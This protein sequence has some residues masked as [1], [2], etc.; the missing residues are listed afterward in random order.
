MGTEKVSG[1][2]AAGASN[3]LNYITL[4]AEFEKKNNSSKAAQ[5]LL[6]AAEVARDG[7]LDLKEIAELG[8][9]KEIDREVD[10]SMTLKSGGTANSEITEAEATK[11]FEV[12]RKWAE[13]KYHKLFKTNEAQALK[14]AQDEYFEAQQF[15]AAALDEAIKIAEGNVSL[16]KSAAATSTESIEDFLKNIKKP[17]SQGGGPVFDSNLINNILVHLKEE[18]SKEKTTKVSE[19]GSQKEAILED[20][21]F[22][23]EYLNLPNTTREVRERATQAQQTAGVGRINP[24]DARFIDTSPALTVGQQI[25]TKGNLNKSAYIY[26]NTPDFTTLSP[27]NK[28]NVLKQ[29]IT[30]AIADEEHLLDSIGLNDDDYASYIA[31]GMAN[32][33]ELLP[34]IKA[35]FANV[36]TKAEL[37]KSYKNLGDSSGQEI[38]QENA[39]TEVEYLIT[40]M[41]DPQNTEF[42]K[43]IKLERYLSSP[44]NK[45]SLNTKT[46]EYFNQ[47]GKIKVQDGSLESVISAIKEDLNRTGSIIDPT[48]RPRIASPELNRQ[49]DQLLGTLRDVYKDSAGSVIKKD[50]A[51]QAQKTAGVN[52]ILSSIDGLGLSSIPQSEIDNYYTSHKEG[53]SQEKVTV[54]LRIF[55]GSSGPENLGEPQTFVKGKDSLNQ[56]RYF[57]V[58]KVQGKDIAIEVTDLPPAILEAIFSNL[59]SQDAEQ[60]FMVKN[61]P[62]GVYKRYKF[63]VEKK[64]TVSKLYE[65]VVSLPTYLDCQVVTVNNKKI[66]VAE[67]KKIS[68]VVSERLKAEK[69]AGYW[70]NPSQNLPSG[71][72][73][74]AEIIQ[75]INSAKAAL[76]YDQYQPAKELPPL[77]KENNEQVEKVTS[78]EA[79]QQNQ[80]NTYV[81]QANNNPQ[82]AL[83][84]IF[85]LFIVSGVAEAFK[86][87]CVVEIM[88]IISKDNVTDSM[89]DALRTESAVSFNKAL[90]DLFKKAYGTLKDNPQFKKDKAQN[91]IRKLLDDSSFQ[92]ET[93]APAGP[94]PAASGTAETSNDSTARTVSELQRQLTL[95]FNATNDM[96]RSMTLSIIMQKAKRIVESSP[97]TNIESL[98]TVISSNGNDKVTGLK[99]ALKNF[100]SAQKSTYEPEKSKLDKFFQELF[101]DPDFKLE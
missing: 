3:L 1:V 23:H 80:L 82:D 86:E 75:Q 42:Q 61:T 90:S 10:S 22:Y 85:Q 59:P 47:E 51:E 58:E 65:G 50:D 27:E 36:R 16:L 32:S 24:N 37:I 95:Y 30:S 46:K 11:F 31:K 76:S 39:A 12:T 43:Q 97:A 15:E 35:Y 62:A 66:L 91:F 49:I 52:E 8:F 29:L 87:S 67:L 79:D 20:L 34:V 2:G 9:N 19:L 78:G 6:K 100:Y 48:R 70:N 77:P 25:I 5:I 101:T 38:S 17:N 73:N 18:F 57:R 72:E 54:R 83:K 89:A 68:E 13:L 99:E 14:M 88:K 7:K 56:S 53:L 92:F 93:S 4:R 96:A 69:I 74:R 55:E 60:I 41:K 84:G 81:T 26:Y 71:L 33:R 40:N 94:N 45:V 44:E 21:C 98:K 28:K 63:K 64:E